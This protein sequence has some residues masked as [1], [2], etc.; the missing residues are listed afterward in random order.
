MPFDNRDEGPFGD[1]ERLLDARSRIVD[2]GRW[3]KGRFRD[4][5]RYCMVGAQSEAC[6]S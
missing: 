5:D 2:P 4:G 1:I 6:A 3:I